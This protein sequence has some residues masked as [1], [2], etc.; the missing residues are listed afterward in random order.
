[1]E[2]NILVRVAL[3]AF[4]KQNMLKCLVNLIV[5]GD[6]PPPGGAAAAIKVVSSTSFQTH[7]SL[8]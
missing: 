7:S 6:L 3:S 1:M 5:S 8:S 4:G 2:P